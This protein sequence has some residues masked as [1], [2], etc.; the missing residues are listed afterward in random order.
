MNWRC[1]L[2]LP[3]QPVLLLLEGPQLHIMNWLSWMREDQLLPTGLCASLCRS[4]GAAFPW[5][6]LASLLAGIGSGLEG[7]G[8]GHDFLHLTVVL[9]FIH[10]TST[11][12]VVSWRP[13]QEEEMQPPCVASA[14]QSEVVV[15]TFKLI[16]PW[17]ENWA[18]TSL[19]PLLS[20]PSASMGPV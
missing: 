8:Q 5:C 14:R 9:Q 6:F 15:A 20:E 11:K 3:P 17:L 12:A 1:P 13:N 4:T 19:C 18:L 7:S 2:S 16:T 10:L